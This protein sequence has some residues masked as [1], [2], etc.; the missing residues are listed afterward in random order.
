MIKQED[1]YPIG[2]IT[3]KHALKG[4]VVFCFTD[5]IF[6]RTDCDY[7]ICEIEGILVPFFI[8]NYRFRSEDSAL[9]K[10][11][12]IDT[13]ESAQRLIG[14]NVYF[15]KKFALENEDNEMPL[16]YFTGFDIKD[17][18]GTTAGKIVDIDDS[19]ENRLFVLTGTDGRQVLVPANEDLITDI[20]F[21]NK[22]ITMNLPLGITE[23]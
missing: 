19:T 6:D 5:D 20:D 18:D 2:K 1:V 13:E 8:E 10:F 4:E 12:D 17:T 11:E 22:I 16:S 9:V 23:L 14:A 15:E 3:K 7:L 21:D